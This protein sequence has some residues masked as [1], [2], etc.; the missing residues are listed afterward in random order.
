MRPELPTASA[1]T[2]QAPSAAV[3]NSAP[4]Q[5]ARCLFISWGKT[6]Q[7]SGA[8]SVEQATNK[9]DL[10]VDPQA[11]ELSVHR[12]AVLAADQATMVVKAGANDLVKLEE[13]GWT[14]APSEVSIEGHNYGLWINSGAYLWIDRSATVQQVL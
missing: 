5:P 12:A 6:V 9:L 4:V 8:T 13:G 11:N 10:A 2:S 7:T 1:G 14:L 3:D